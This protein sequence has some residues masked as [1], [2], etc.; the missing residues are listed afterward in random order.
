[1]TFLI[2]KSKLDN[3]LFLDI[4][5][6]SQHATYS[7]MDSDFQ[8]L[9]DKKAKNLLKFQKEE[10]SPDAS[11]RLYE[12]K[13]A[14]FAEF[15]KVV[16]ITVAYLRKHKKE[17]EVRIKSFYGSDEKEVLKD[18]SSLINKH[19]DEPKKYF[20]CGHNIKEFDVPFLG[21][22]FLVNNIKLPD[23]FNLIGKKPWESKHLIDTLEMWKFGDY[24]NYVSLDLLAKVLGVSSPKVNMD[25]S[26]VGAAFW[27]EDKLEEIKDYCELD[28]ITSVN[29]FLRLNGNDVV[30]EV[31]RVKD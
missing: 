7:E 3:I 13:A 30:E 29:V 24:K 15:A 17:Y 12:E 28:V 14:I 19:F 31:I 11:A 2:Q 26:M 25:G 1:M 8:K 21:R 6:V 4:E 20:I 22:R 5:T 16:C 9:W 23:I 18:F 27:K 10:F